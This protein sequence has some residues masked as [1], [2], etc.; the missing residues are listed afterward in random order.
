MMLAFAALARPVASVRPGVQRETGHPGGGGRRGELHSAR[1][2]SAYTDAIRALED[3]AWSLPEVSL[4]EPHAFRPEDSDQI[5][6]L[7]NQRLK[8]IRGKL[9]DIVQQKTSTSPRSHRPSRLRL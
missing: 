7:V 6:A 8:T 1:I 2:R 4:E 9:I 3:S 5:R